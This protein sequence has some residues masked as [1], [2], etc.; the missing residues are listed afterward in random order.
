MNKDEKDFDSIVVGGFHTA[1]DR[2][3]DLL[4]K[5][6][7][8]RNIKEVQRLAKMTLTWWAK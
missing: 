6:C 3:L 1:Q 5:A 2:T 7:K 4:A 8:E